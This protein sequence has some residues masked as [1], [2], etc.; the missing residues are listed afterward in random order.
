MS[1]NFPHVRPFALT[2]ARRGAHPTSSLKELNLMATS[3]RKIHYRYTGAA[4]D[5]TSEHVVIAG[6]GNG[7][8]RLVLANQS[9]QR[10]EDG[11]RYT[12]RTRSSATHS[13]SLWLF[14]FPLS[15]SV[16]HLTQQCFHT[17]S[18]IDGGLTVKGA[19]EPKVTDS[20]LTTRELTDKFSVPREALQAVGR[21]YC[22]RIDDDGARSP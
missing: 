21:G 4:Y 7:A 11:F 9:R 17:P 15:K 6:I 5:R 22:H 1:I 8:S 20:I 13:L 14:L 16:E 2:S 18:M 19:F 10:F 3:N 12:T